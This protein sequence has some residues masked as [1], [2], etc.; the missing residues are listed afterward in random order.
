MGNVHGVNKTTDVKP[1]QTIIVD[2]PY[3]SKVDLSTSVGFF[4][5]IQHT[6]VQVALMVLLVMFNHVSF[7][8]IVQV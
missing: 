2:L 7:P 5:V 6:M 8:E 3:N 1:G 4:M